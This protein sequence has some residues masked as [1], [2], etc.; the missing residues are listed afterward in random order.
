MRLIPRD[1]QFFPMFGDLAQKLS[2]SADLLAKLFAEPDRLQELVQKIKDVEHEADVLTHDIIV[3]IDKSFVT[4]IDRE[5]IHLLASR[6]DDVIDVVDGVARRAQMFRI[7]EFR[8]QAAELAGVLCRA[9]V[10]LA[11]SVQN[12]K[13]P[14]LI[15]QRSGELKRLEEEGDAIY[16]SAIGGLFDDGAE[17]LEVLK[18]K[19]LFDKLEDAVD[20]CDDVWNV[21]ESVAIKNS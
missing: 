3:R 9:A 5:D 8:P 6:L 2:I 14:K 20:L 12:L 10:V 7:R 13:K 19:E 15:L 4:P 16:H 17:A 11:E 18:W 1:E 21:I